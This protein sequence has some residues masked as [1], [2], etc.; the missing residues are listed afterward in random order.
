M[1]TATIDRQQWAGYY[2]GKGVYV[3]R[4]CPKAPTRLTYTISSS[5]KQLD[6]LH[7]S[8]LGTQMVLAGRL[9][10]VIIMVCS[11]VVAHSQSETKFKTSIF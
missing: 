8:R 11:A 4:Y 6:G 10:I 3:L 5:I 2:L 7:G 9:T 1:Q